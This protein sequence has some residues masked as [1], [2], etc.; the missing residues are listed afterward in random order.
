M[1]QWLRIVIGLPVLLGI[2][3]LPSQLAL[4]L[5]SACHDGVSSAALVVAV[6]VNRP[7]MDKTMSDDQVDGMNRMVMDRM[8]QLMNTP[9]IDRTLMN[10]LGR[11]SL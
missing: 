11:S 10:R 5:S 6:S 4:C 8:L 9:L 3:L 7:L 1:G 2:K